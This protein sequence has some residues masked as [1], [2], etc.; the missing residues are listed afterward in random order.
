VL[1]NKHTNK[2]TDATD[3]IQLSSL[4]YDVG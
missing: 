4:H 1:T 3:N 2:Q